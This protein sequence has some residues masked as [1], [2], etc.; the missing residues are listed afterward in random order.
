[1]RPTL[2]TWPCACPSS[3]GS[4][5]VATPR[6]TGIC[7]VAFASSQPQNFSPQ[8]FAHTGSR[9][10]V[11]SG[12]LLAS[13]LFIPLASPGPHAVPNPVQLSANTLQLV[14]CIFAPGDHAAI[15]AT[16]EARCGSGLPLWASPTPEGLER[17]R[18]AVLKLSSGSLPEFER[19]IATANSDWRDVL[20]AAGFGSSALA[21][22][23][24]LNEQIHT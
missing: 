16:L 14:R 20:V 15:I 3:D 17:I 21:H 2:A 19:A 1:M 24:W 18:F 9:R 6:H 22:I 8:R 23:H 7:F 13:S 12:T 10:S 5:Q 11:S 4:P